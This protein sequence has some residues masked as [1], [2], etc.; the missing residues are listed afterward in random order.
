MYAGRWDAKILRRTSLKSHEIASI[1]VGLDGL[2]GDNLRFQFGWEKMSVS[3]SCT[4]SRSVEERSL[5]RKFSLIGC[6]CA[7]P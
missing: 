5:S 1:R 3:D 4:L 6:T 7:L 2:V